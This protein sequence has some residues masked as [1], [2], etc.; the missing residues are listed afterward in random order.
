MEIIITYRFKIYTNLV[1]DNNKNIWELPNFSNGRTK[2]LRKLTYYEPRKAYRYN[3][4][5]LKKDRLYN[6][7]YEVSEVYGFKNSNCPF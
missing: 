4:G 5:Y 1:V 3:N 7:M 2:N 6:L